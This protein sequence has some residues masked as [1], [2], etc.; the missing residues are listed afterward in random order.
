MVNP[1]NVLM[2]PTSLLAA[3]A[4]T[5]ALV[6]GG[7]DNT[8]GASEDNVNEMFSQL[9]QRPDIETVQAGYLAL[10]EQIRARLVDDLG[11]KA[12]IPETEEPISGSACPGPM[13]AVSDAQVRHYTSGFSPG[14]ISDADWPRAVEI[15]TG[16][17][18]QHGFGTPKT[19]VDRHGDH[20]IAIYDTYGAELI[21]GTA[22][23]T[24]LSLA[25]G[26]H[27]THEAKKRGKPEPAEYNY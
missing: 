16:I 5:A 1:G 18:S 4:A 8:S 7:C 10:L 3:L 11:L 26:C 27:L 24:I 13:S 20:E 17:T 6:V 12:F 25:T 15:V 2:K 23:N 9:M 14:S 21:F 19:V 22:N